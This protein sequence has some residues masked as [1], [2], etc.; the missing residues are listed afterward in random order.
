MGLGLGSGPPQNY[1]P[2]NIEMAEDC[3]NKAPAMPRL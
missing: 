2:K 3:F 1:L